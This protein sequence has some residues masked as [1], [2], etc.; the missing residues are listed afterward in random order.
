MIHVAVALISVALAQPQFAQKAQKVATPER[1]FESALFAGEED[2]AFG[3]QFEC[4]G[5]AAA[6]YREC[7]A[8]GGTREECRIV[9]QMTYQA[10][11]DKCETTC[12]EQCFIDARILYREC[13]ENGG[14]V[15]E[16]Y[17]MAFDALLEC[18]ETCDP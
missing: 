6:A 7:R 14:R 5:E 12:E 16:C 8:G 1:P 4:V 2:G 17:R 11:I 18:L 3:C 15:R 10:C 13:R 9:F